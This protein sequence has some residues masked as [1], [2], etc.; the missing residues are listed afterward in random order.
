MNYNKDKVFQAIQ[1]IR[2]PEAIELILTQAWKHWL[3]KQPQ[4]IQ[5]KSTLTYYRPFDQARIVAEARVISD[6]ET[7][8]TLIHLFFHVFAEAADAVQQLEQ[9]YEQAI[10]PSAVLPVFLIDDWQTVVWTIP[11]APCLHELTD[12]LQPEYFCRSLISLSDLPSA[13]KDCLSPQLFRYV[14]FKRAI[15]TWESPCTNR[16]YF[17]KVC[18]KAEF[19]RVVRNF[20]QMYAAAKHLSFVVPQPVAVD[21]VSCTF[22]M[23]ALTGEQFTTL[24]YQTKPKSFAKVGRVLGQLHQVDLNPETVWTPE[25]ELHTLYRAMHEVKLALPYLTTSINRAIAQII[26]TK[27]Q[28]KFRTNHLIHGNLFGDQILYSSKQIGIVDWD[29]L[30]LGDPHY[31]V[32]RLIAH[33]IYLAGREGLAVKKVRSCIT[34]LLQ[35]YEQSIS[36]TLD[37]NCLTWHI[38]SQLLLRGKISSLR[39]LPLGWQEDLQFVVAEAEW[40]IE[41]CSEYIFLPALN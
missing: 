18:I 40:L 2:K 25:K 7:E 11:H 39:K 32:G 4:A 14:P 12:L 30:S 29:T 38:S 35:S 17:V 8:S 3:G 26:A 5:V 20:R 6:N 13:P 10:P 23:T 15:L 37:Q 34:A 27:K 31:D 19:S 1:Q 33:F 16:R 24:M 36:W 21:A 41:G 28:I 22:S 9:G